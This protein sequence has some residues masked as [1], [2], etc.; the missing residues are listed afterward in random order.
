MRL[1]A[2]KLI[3]IKSLS[4]HKRQA[5]DMQ[6]KADKNEDK[7]LETMRDLLIESEEPKATKFKRFKN[8][9]NSYEKKKPKTFKL[10]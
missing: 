4:G 8:T 1:I 2:G 5:D 6:L 7:L 9:F 3:N 10:T